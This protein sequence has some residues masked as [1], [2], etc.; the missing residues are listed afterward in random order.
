MQQSQGIYDKRLCR[1]RSNANRQRRHDRSSMPD[2]HS[3]DRRNDYPDI[4]QR[5]IPDHNPFQSSFLSPFPAQGSRRSPGRPSPNRGESDRR[6]SL[7]DQETQRYLRGSSPDVRVK[8]PFHDR[9]PTMSI[10]TTAAHPRFF[11]PNPLNNPNLLD[12]VISPRR[13]SR[14]HSR[15]KHHSRHSRHR[16]RRSNSR[17]SNHRDDEISGQE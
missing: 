15:S 5:A 1:S 10:P 2:E 7:F 13:P 12:P 8:L 11:S 16:H 4:T 6:S 17:H 3:D 9:G 14:N